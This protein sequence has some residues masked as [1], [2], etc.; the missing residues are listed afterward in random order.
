MVFH[1][2]RHPVTTGQSQIDLLMSNNLNAESGQLNIEHK[3]RH[4]HP[5]HSRLANNMTIDEQSN[6]NGSHPRGGITM[7]VNK[8][9]PH[10]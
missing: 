8:Y 4:V 1:P 5:F 9:V 7:Q 6:R 3:N 2:Q 10:Y